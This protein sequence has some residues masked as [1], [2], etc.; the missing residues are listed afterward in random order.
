MPNFTLSF[1]IFGLQMTLSLIVYWLLA[2]WYVKPWL[3]QKDLNTAL[4][5]LMF[6]H[7]LRHL[8]LIALVPSVVDPNFPRDWVLPLAWGDAVAEVL[9]IACLITLHSRSSIAIP[10]TWLFNIIGMLDFAFV[11]GKGS[12]I[13]VTRFHFGGFWYVPT[14]WVPLLIVAH[15]LMFQL[16]LGRPAANPAPRSAGR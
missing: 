2:S 1:E 6:P 14:F 15:I 12:L 3:A 13:D 16:L 8:G 11:I 10:L 9:A 7:A 4:I 5:F